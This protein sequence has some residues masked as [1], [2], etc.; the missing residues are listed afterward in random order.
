MATSVIKYNGETNWSP[1]NNGIRYRIK[2]GIVF[3]EGFSGGSEITHI[4]SGTTN[5][6]TLPTGYRPKIDSYAPFANRAINACSGFAKIEA[7]TGILSISSSAAT[8]YW[9][10]QASYPL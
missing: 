6:M 1:I 7:S 8:D 5:V 3:I 2:D 4:N 10:I 9:S